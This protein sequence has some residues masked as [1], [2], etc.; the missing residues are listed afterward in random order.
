MNAGMRARAR[1]RGSALAGA[2]GRG[3]RAGRWV[4]R[5]ALVLLLKGCRW[6]IWVITPYGEVC[7]FYPSCSTY[8][9]EAV[10]RHG[11][12]RGGWLGIRRLARCHPWN[13]GGVDLVPSACGTPD[14]EPADDTGGVSRQTGEPAAV[15]QAVAA[16]RRAPQPTD[17][18][19]RHV[20]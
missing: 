2:V 9:V 16:S 12:I 11:V 1:S 17:A 6:T 5:G 10:E 20:A 13:P 18:T 19:S 14:A 3:W 7:R 4:I 15:A 8:A